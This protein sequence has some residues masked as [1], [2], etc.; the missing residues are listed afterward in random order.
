MSKK[1]RE[2]EIITSFSSIIVYMVNV[3]LKY[4]C[5]LVYFF[6]LKYIKQLYIL[7]ND[8]QDKLTLTMMPYFVCIYFSRV[9]T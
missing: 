1:Q 6:N 3:F 4:L 5:Q 2:R 9:T 7:L 8:L